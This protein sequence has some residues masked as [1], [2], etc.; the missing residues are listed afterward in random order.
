MDL[1]RWWHRWSQFRDRSGSEGAGQ[2]VDK[3]TE[4]GPGNLNAEMVARMVHLSRSS[5]LF[6]MDSG[7]ENALA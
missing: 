3:A 7:A 5:C 4:A 1:G 2:A 6:T